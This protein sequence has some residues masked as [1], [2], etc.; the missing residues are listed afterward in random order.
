MEVCVMGID[1]ETLYKVKAVNVVTRIF[2]RFV[3]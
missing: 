1:L 3:G 2:D